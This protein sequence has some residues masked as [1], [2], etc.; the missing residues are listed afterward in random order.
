[1]KSA[2]AKE[3]TMKA[4]LTPSIARLVALAA[5]A[6]MAATVLGNGHWT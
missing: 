3:T 4:I 6:A 5:M 2:T 1:M